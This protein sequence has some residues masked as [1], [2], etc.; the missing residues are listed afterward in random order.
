MATRKHYK[1]HISPHRKKKTRKRRHENA[2]KLFPPPTV[3]N[4]YSRF[5]FEWDDTDFGPIHP[6]YVK[7]DH[8]FEYSDGDDDDKL[9][10]DDDGGGDDDDNGTGDPGDGP[11]DGD[12]EEKP[13][14]TDDKH[15]DNEY[16]IETDTGKGTGLDYLGKEEDDKKPPPPTDDKHPDNEYPIETNT[17]NGTELDYLGK[18]EDKRE[19]AAAPM[20]SKPPKP[21]PVPSLYSDFPI[22]NDNKGDIIYMV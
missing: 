19:E 17:G 4:D 9:D 6:P 14:P 21:V 11:G 7:P 22:S 3:R 8:N 5:A 2:L 18:E 1:V 15:P 16:P 20:P 13:P 10:D 12:D